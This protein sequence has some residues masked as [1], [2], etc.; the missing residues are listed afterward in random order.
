LFEFYQKNGRY[1]LNHSKNPEEKFLC[2]WVVTQKGSYKKGQLSKERIDILNK[3]DGWVWE[4]DLDKIWNE[5]HQKWVDFYQKYKKTPS[6]GSIN[7]EEKSL[8]SWAHHQKNYYKTKKSYLT[9]ERIEILNN[10]EGWI[11]EDNKEEKWNENYQKWVEFYQKNGNR[12]SKDSKNKEERSL[13]QWA[14]DMRKFYKKGKLSQ[15]KIDILNNTY[16]W[17]WEKNLDKI[18]NEN[19]QKWTEFYQKNEKT[20]SSSSKN[21]EEIF[22]GR[23]GSLQRKKYKKG[24]L[25][26]ESIDILNKNPGWFWSKEEDEIQSVSSSDSSIKEDESATQS[27]TSVQVSITKKVRPSKR[28]VKSDDE[29]KGDGSSTKHQMGLLE[30]YHQ[31][32]KKMNAA[33]YVSKITKEEFNA[34]H[35]VAD[36][37]DSRDK[38]GEG[39]NDKMAQLLKK[40]NRKSYSAIDLGCGRNRFKT[41]PEVNKMNWTS[42]DAVAIDDSVIEAD[43]ANLP[44]EEEEFDFAIMSR[45]LWAVNYQD[46]L[47]ETARI[48]KHNGTLL[49]CEAYSRWCKKDANG[50]NILPQ[51][52]ENAGFSIV[53][54]E[55]TF[56]T[57]D[58]VNTWQYIIA[59]KI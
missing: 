46:V 11:W 58:F 23:W 53:N 5:T 24:K 21:K 8:G 45:A 17:I 20:P 48:L 55:G 59:R 35:D 1:P 34:Y 25:S 2:L 18:W 3:T 37:H 14:S 51:A 19:F 4:K 56:E 39:P 33:T 16:G 50:E 57:E 26:Q 7:K 9:K 30:K 15:E 38:E 31:R 41:R 42:I 40:F 12:P 36:E 49:I 32:F 22:L 6:H 28:K 44:F 13:G 52:I 10:T 54:E 27:E 47:K 43:I 29:P